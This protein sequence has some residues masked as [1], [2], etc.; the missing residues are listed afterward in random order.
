MLQKLLVPSVTFQHEMPVRRLPEPFASWYEL[1]CYTKSAQGGSFHKKNSHTY[2]LYM[3]IYMD[4]MSIGQL[5]WIAYTVEFYQALRY[6]AQVRQ[7]LFLC[8]ARNRKKMQWAFA[9]NQDHSFHVPGD[10]YYVYL[11]QI[12]Y[13]FKNV[14][15][16]DLVNGL[17]IT[18][19]NAK[20]PQC[21]NNV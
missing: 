11:L 19:V 5:C 7:C 20:V 18:C 14:A 16:A 1:S 9:A 15:W 8:T 6:R 21:K 13:D 10:G 12:A 4:C 2:R 17:C 3:S